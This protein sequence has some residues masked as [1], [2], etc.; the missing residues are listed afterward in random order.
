MAGIQGRWEGGGGGGGGGG[1]CLLSASVQ[2]ILAYNL[3]S[4]IIITI[5][6]L[7]VNIFMHDQIFR[8][9]KK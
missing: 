2:D 9:G 8:L 5:V 7:S 1:Y 6:F 4:E 3:L